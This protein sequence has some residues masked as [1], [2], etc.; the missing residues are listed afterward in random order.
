MVVGEQFRHERADGYKQLGRER[1]RP[2]SVDV[3]VVVM[4]RDC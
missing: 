1:W 2:R 4:E 3:V